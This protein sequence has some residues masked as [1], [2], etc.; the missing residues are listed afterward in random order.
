MRVPA[1]TAAQYF[2]GM[3]LGAQPDWLWTLTMLS[4]IPSLYLTYP[5]AALFNLSLPAGDLVEVA[6]PFGPA[7]R[8]APPD[9]ALMALGTMVMVGLATYL[10]QGVTELIADHA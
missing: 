10:A 5:L 9:L 3:P 7:F 8:V 1:V 2:V 4:A 6:T